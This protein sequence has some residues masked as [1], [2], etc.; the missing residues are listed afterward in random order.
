MRIRIE[1]AADDELSEATE[2]LAQKSDGLAA[3]FIEDMRAARDRLLAFPNC[4][5]PLG[6]GI[7]RLILSRFPYQL[8]YRIE[9]DEIR[10]YAIAHLKRKPGY[11]LDRGTPCHRCFPGSG[12]GCRATPAAKGGRLHRGRARHCSKPFSG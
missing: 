7:R 1:P 10:V 8:V 11:W 12:D 6:G 4:G 3:G 5:S 2:Y 9:R